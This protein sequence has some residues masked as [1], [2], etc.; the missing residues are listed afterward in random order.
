MKIYTQCHRVPGIDYRPTAKTYLLHDA[1]NDR[2]SEAIA[3]LDTASNE[4]GHAF[5]EGVGDCAY[6]G[7][8]KIYWLAREWS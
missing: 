6:D 3:L 7:K 2:Q 5:I 4:L 8:D 1:I